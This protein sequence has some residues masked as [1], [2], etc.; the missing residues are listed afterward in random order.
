[1][2]DENERTE[3]LEARRDSAAN[4]L[5]TWAA[6]LALLWFANLPPTLQ[7]LNLPHTSYCFPFL[8]RTLTTA[9]NNPKHPVGLLYHQLVFKE[10]LSYGTV[11]SL[12]VQSNHFQQLKSHALEPEI[13]GVNLQLPNQWPHLPS[14]GKW[15]EAQDRYA[16]WEASLP[17]VGLAHY[18]TVL[19]GSKWHESKYYICL[20][21]GLVREKL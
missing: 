2:P 17:Q 8:Q 13:C 6:S 20:V 19:R 4:G 10:N 15:P 5:H 12:V 14:S 16:L 7:N 1:M 9:I 18:L 11:R 21:L 3:L